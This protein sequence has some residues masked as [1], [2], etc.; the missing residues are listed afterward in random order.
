SV[1]GEYESAIQTLHQAAEYF[2]D[3]Y[4]IEYRLAGLYYMFIEMDKGKI[5]L[6]KGLKLNFKQQTLL[7]E[8]F[9]KV[10]NEKKVQALIQKHTPKNP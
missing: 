10:W 2:P 4:E 6:E 7:Q 8:L 3:S 1:L 5:H 9:P